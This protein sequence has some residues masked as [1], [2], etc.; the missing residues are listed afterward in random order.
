[1]NMTVSTRWCLLLAALTTCRG[2]MSPS[3]E[4]PFSDT[5]PPLP[6]KSGRQHGTLVSPGRNTAV[7]NCESVATCACQWKYTV[8]WHGECSKPG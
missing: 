1:M 8:T 5:F 4:R 3:G 2:R 7:L 6:S